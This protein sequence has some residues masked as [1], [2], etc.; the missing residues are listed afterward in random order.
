MPTPRFELSQYFPV[1][2]KKIQPVHLWRTLHGPA[3]RGRAQS[4]MVREFKRVG[5]VTSLRA[6]SSHFAKYGYRSFEGSIL[7][8]TLIEKLR[9][10]TGLLTIADVSDLLCFHPV[11]L[12]D[13]ARAG[14]LPAMRIAGA[15]RFDPAELAAWVEARRTW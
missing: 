10:R 14:R 4:L 5:T 13:W 15:W 11:T 8:E 3:T 2:P 1:L 12:R 9:A 6:I 7:V